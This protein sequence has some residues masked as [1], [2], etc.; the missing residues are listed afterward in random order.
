MTTSAGTTPTAPWV[1]DTSTFGAR[2]ALVRQ[3]MGW[4]NVKTAAEQCGVPVES[5]RNWERDGMEPRR[6]VTI[7]MAIATR[8]GVDV[9]WLIRGPG[10]GTLLPGN[11]PRLDPLAIRVL[12]VEHGDGRRRPRGRV[13]AVRSTTRPAT[14]TPRT[15][16]VPLPASA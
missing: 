13:T 5:W 1:P 7:A 10:D 15:L 2:L 9:D 4:G 8:T 11:P 16:S 12:P 6:L 14:S 3:K